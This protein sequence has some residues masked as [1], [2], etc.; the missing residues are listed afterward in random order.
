M[1]N[2]TKADHLGDAMD[3]VYEE[4]KYVVKARTRFSCHRIMPSSR[5]HKNEPSDFVKA[6]LFLLA[7][8]LSVPQKETRNTE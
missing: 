6:G 7:E 2:L 1:D 3:I 8:R 5:D 4:K